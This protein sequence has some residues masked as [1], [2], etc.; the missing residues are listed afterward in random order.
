M[1]MTSYQSAGVCGAGRT[2]TCVCYLALMAF[3]PVAWTA[4]GINRNEIHDAEGQWRRAKDFIRQ[5]TA[6]RLELFDEKGQ[7]SG[8]PADEPWRSMELSAYVNPFLESGD[9]A[10][11][12]KA[13]AILENNNLH[14]LDLA[15]ALVRHRQRLSDEAVARA[16]PIV[17]RKVE[18]EFQEFRWKYFQG[19]ND[20]FQLM[21]AATV[22]M[23]GTY[24]GEA[25][26]VQDAVERLEQ[27]KALL[28]RRG[29]AS[30]FNSPAYLGLHLHPLAL[31]AETTT[32]QRLRD[33]AIDLETRTWLDLLSH[34]HPACG[35]QAGP[36][37]REY[38]FDIY[39]AG[40][41]R[42][43]LHLLLGERLPGD[44][45]EGYRAESREHGLVRAANR[46][47][48]P[49][50][51]P[52]WLVEWLLARRYPF[53]V[54]GTADGAPSFIQLEPDR[55]GGLFH[56]NWKDTRDEDDRLDTLPAWNSRLVTYMTEDY[57]LG[58]TQRMFTNVTQ[59]HSFVATVPA[60]KPLTSIRDA[61]RIYARYVVD[62]QQPCVTWQNAGGRKHATGP[63]AF[64]DAGQSICLQHEK[65]A[66]VLYRPHV[67][68]DHRPRS[69]KTMIVIPNE[70]FGDGKPRGDEIYIGE[71]PV[72]NHQG[73]S[74]ESA[75]VFLR[76]GD[77]YL[78]FIPL[79]NH[80]E[81]G[82]VLD[83]KVAVRVRQEGK[84]LGISLY[85]FEGEAVDLNPR[86]CTLVG[87]GFICEMGSKA[88]CGD[89]TTFRRRHA[90][91]DVTDRYRRTVH[92]RG[93]YSREVIYRRE[94]LELATEYNP[95]TGG[96]R[97]QTI[98]GKP[99]QTPQL[100]ATDLP[101]DRVP[102]LD[103]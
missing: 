44:W 36:W 88:E 59:C 85:N 79:V 58:T 51:C 46:A 99:P 9:P 12:R 89:F 30:E 20:N 78:A 90:C 91:P 27:F 54:I 48:V 72:S 7:W 32:D 37:S 74:V 40:F 35:T 28:T 24:T 87:N 60:T 81:V 80:D 6:A 11:V 56:W 25:K 66:M 49:Y 82:K 18:Q 5:F 63:V 84:A 69:L 57:S 97:Y 22:A 71:Q 70:D 19:D 53:T 86:Q 47:S 55:A 10:A 101:R 4:E 103:N 21:A 8:D 39:G 43:N 83:R 1:R 95:T 26:Y 62:E 3:A 61:V 75:T 92:S 67:I 64:S 17:R 77:T 65:T 76:I 68:V 33:L 13:N 96:L 14:Q 45:L 52:K 73:E 2:V 100:D 93:A 15:Y 50:H 16:E 42:L 94:G 102:F 34:Y 41:T 38:N 31:I 98:N 23:W 29:F